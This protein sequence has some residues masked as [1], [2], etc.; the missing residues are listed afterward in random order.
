MIAADQMRN[1]GLRLHL[2]ISGAARQGSALNMCPYPG[3]D[4]RSR[5]DLHVPCGAPEPHDQD[6]DGPHDAADERL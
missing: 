6:A 3:G 1:R 2:A 5:E 4:L